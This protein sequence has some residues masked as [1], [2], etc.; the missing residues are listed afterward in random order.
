MT[1]LREFEP[2]GW[3]ELCAKLQSA[4]NPEEFQAIVEQ[5]NRLLTAHEKTHPETLGGKTPKP[6]VKKGK[7][8]KAR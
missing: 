2:P 8:A 6:A 4:K 3:R 1:R 7:S 5:I